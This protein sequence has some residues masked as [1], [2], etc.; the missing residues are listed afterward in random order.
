MASRPIIGGHV[1]AAGGLYTVFE[2]ARA[3]GAECIQMFGA[4]PRAW[5]ARKPLKKEADLFKAA[6]QR[7]NVQAVYLHAAYLVNLASPVQD[8]VTKSIKCLS[9]HLR[10]ADAIGA[11][12][13]IFHIG[14]GK[15]LPKE[16]ALLKAADA[17]K[18]ILKEVPGR[19]QLIIENAAG[20]GQKIGANAKDIGT[21]MK[22]IGS[23]RVKVCFDTAHA[24]E[25]G[26][27]E[28]YTPA[29]TEA[30]LDDWEEHVGL[31]NIVALHVNDSKTLYNSHHDRHENIGEGHIGLAGFKAL[32]KNKRLHDKA[33]LLEVPGFDNMGPDRKNIEILRSCFSAS[34]KK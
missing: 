21:L 19:T 4:S 8:L 22:M 3:I 30:L 34:A 18:V 12:G 6:R 14:S 10:I 13:L 27:I 15:E 1:S 32:A 23:S 11:E 2:R 31:M 16:E 26:L 33:W 29:F 28:K 5:L 24:F 7:S 25:A 20:G 9:D 17:M